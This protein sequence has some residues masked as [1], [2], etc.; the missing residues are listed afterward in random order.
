MG[1]QQSRGCKRGLQVQLASPK[2]QV[3]E[4]EP[5]RSDSL[6]RDTGQLGGSR[7]RPPCPHAKVGKG[8][9]QK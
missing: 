2:C 6:C 7:L 5:G 9:T 3:Q 4:C 1:P 8:V